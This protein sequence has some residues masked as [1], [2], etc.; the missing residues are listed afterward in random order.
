MSTCMCRS[1]SPTFRSSRRFCA[2]ISSPSFPEFED[3]VHFRLVGLV[4]PTIGVEPHREVRLR[5]YTFTSGGL[6][7]VRFSL[8]ERR[9]R[10]EPHFVLDCSLCP[11]PDFIMGRGNFDNTIIMASQ[12]LSYKSHP[13][14][15][16]HEEKRK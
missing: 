5:L 14:P 6:R 3:D 16:D 7:R 1:T 4:G 15:Y 8:S 13:F 11:A 2:A 9:H 10:V 12:A